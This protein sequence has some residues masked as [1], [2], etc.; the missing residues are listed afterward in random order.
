MPHKWL[1]EVLVVSFYEKNKHLTATIRTNMK[2]FRV[3]GT[4]ASHVH[5]L[6]RTYPC[7]HYG[8]THLMHRS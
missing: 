2:Q 3:V 5:R 7:F 4:K 1:F 6:Q 8:A